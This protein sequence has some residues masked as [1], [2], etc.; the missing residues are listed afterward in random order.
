MLAWGLLL[1]Q[2]EG[3]APL[4]ASPLSPSEGVRN[5]IILLRKQS[6][7]HRLSRH[8]KMRVLRVRTKS[9]RADQINAGSLYVPIG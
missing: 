9:A 1:E 5:N 6:A 2:P 3:L 4:S 8:E 7:N